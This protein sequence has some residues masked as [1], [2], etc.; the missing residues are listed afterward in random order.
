MRALLLL[1]LPAE[2]WFRIFVEQLACKSDPDD[3]S[4]KRSHMGASRLFP[5]FPRGRVTPTTLLWIRHWSPWLLQAY[6]L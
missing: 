5:W 2:S 3:L 6:K 1:P 4:S